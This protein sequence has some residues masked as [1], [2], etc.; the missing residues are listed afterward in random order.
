MVEAMALSLAYF[1]KLNGYGHSY[2]KD[3]TGFSR[4]ACRDG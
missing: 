2:L 1:K 3:S 4:E